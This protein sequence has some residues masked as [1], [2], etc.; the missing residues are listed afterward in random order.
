[1]AI[2]GKPA[3]H[4][5]AVDTEQRG[6]LQARVRL[7]AREEIQ[8][9]EASALGWMSFLNKPGLQVV[10]RLSNRRHRVAHDGIQSAARVVVEGYPQHAL[11]A[12]PIH[13]T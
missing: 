11:P 7:L 3:S 1:M 6:D 2:G 5:I 4:G 8:R 13:I 12:R 10:S 9:V